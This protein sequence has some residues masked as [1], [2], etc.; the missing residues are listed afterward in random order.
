MLWEVDI[1]AAA[2]QPDLGARDVAA[3]AAELQLADKLSITSA[4]GYLIQGDLD[5]AQVERIA[6]S[7]WPI[8]WSSGPWP[9]RWA[10]LA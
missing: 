10:T 6:A 9:P 3:A 7:C 4:R 8:A 1:F 5:R 2:G